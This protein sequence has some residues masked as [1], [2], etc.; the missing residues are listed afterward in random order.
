L[1]RFLHNL[2]LAVA[3]PRL[4]LVY[5][6]LLGLPFLALYLYAGVFSPIHDGLPF[7]FA[8]YLKASQLMAAGG[9]PYTLQGNS[10]VPAVLAGTYIYPPF[11]AWL[12]QPLVRATPDIQIGVFVVLGQ[13]CL[14]VFIWS[15][16]RSLNVRSLQGILF[17]AIAIIGFQPVT[18][19]Y[20]VVQVSILLLPLGGLWLLSWSRDQGWGHFV[21]GIAIGIK[22]IQAPVLLLT[23]VWRRFKWLALAAAGLLVTVL[24]ATPWFFPQYVSQVYPSLRSTSDIRNQSI[25]G[26]LTRVL[27]PGP[28]WPTAQAD[29]SYMDV[30]IIAL[31]F[32]AALVLVSAWALWQAPRN[33]RGRLHGAALVSTLSPLIAP[34]VWGDH[35]AFLIIPILVLGYFAFIER[36]YGAFAIVVATWLMISGGV[37]V[38]TA[39]VL[40]GGY[41]TALVQIMVALAPAAT[42]MLW[43]TAL[44]ECKRPATAVQP[45]ATQSVGTLASPATENIGNVKGS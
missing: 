9:N 35:L 5:L 3:N 14:A 13:I 39:M 33:W 2:I 12:L 1:S 29:M 37:P 30:T 23:V 10:Q 8:T 18:G 21:L 25:S 40:N 41:S 27:H 19:S 26:V 20:S 43:V 22:V 24:V 16:V 38:A 31:L 34:V 4:R 28:L 44:L 6:V 11:W 32:S 17:I 45:L 15:V 36:R 42:I 7:D